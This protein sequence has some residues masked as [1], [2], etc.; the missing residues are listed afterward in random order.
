MEIIDAVKR[1]KYSFK[2][3]EFDNVSDSAKDLIK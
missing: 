2:H 1:A 3:E